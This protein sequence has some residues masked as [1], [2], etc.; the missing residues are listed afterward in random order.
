MGE[1]RMKESV[2]AFFKL[3]LAIVIYMFILTENVIASSYVWDLSFNQKEY[4]S[5]QLDYLVYTDSTGKLTLQEIVSDLYQSKFGSVKVISDSTTV[6]FRKKN[7]TNS[8]VY[9]FSKEGNTLTQEHINLLVIGN[10]VAFVVAMLAI[11]SFIGFLSKHGFK[12]FGWYRIIVGA[13]I[14][15][16]FLF[17]IPLSVV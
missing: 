15:L 17:N 4:K 16:L 10:I 13:I 3:L 8:K 5:D 14:I 1:Y 12:W 6:T 9:D 2:F 7:I 11:K